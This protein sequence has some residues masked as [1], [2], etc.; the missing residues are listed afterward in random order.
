MLTAYII[1]TLVP[2]ILIIFAILYNKTNKD[3]KPIYIGLMI[4]LF[5]LLFG[6]RYNVGVDFPNY[7]QMLQGNYYEKE[8]IEFAFDF[9]NKSIRAFNLPPSVGF[10]TYALI[11]FAFFIFSIKRIPE[12]IPWAI[13]FYFSTTY[14]FLSLNVIRQ[15]MA[16]SIIMYSTWFICNKKILKYLVCIL[17]ASG[18]HTSALIFIPIYFFINHEYFKSQK[19]QFILLSGSFILGSFIQQFI[20]LL[21]PI[22]GRYFLGLDYSDVDILQFMDVN[23]NQDGLGLGY[24]LWY[25][26]DA[27]IIYY[28]PKLKGMIKQPI[29]IIWYNLFFIG[30]LLTF[31]LGAT[32][33]N[34]IN[35]YFEYFKIIIY[36]IFSLF[37]FKSTSKYHFKS[38][39]L[40]SF[41]SLLLVFYYVAIAKKASDCAPFL[42]V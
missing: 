6:L 24:F 3:C 29:F 23:W 19:F 9:L 1:Y 8:N 17:I 42:F 2:L 18:I 32:Y 16:L 31:I 10:I 35:I 25:L 41:L 22:F 30:A 26:I 34:R 38:I 33:L 28:Y 40:L 39:S 36:A 12:L 15:T 21:V 20:W 13:F 4:G 7:W 27:L 37:L 14:I 11:Q 5:S